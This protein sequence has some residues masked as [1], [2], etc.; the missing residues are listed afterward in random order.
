MNSERGNKGYTCGP[1]NKSVEKSSSFPEAVGM[2]EEFQAE[3]ESPMLKLHQ[4][5]RADDAG[6]LYQI[7]VATGSIMGCLY[8]GKTWEEGKDK[9]EELLSWFEP[10]KRTGF[11]RPKPDE[12]NDLT[13]LFNKCRVKVRSAERRLDAL[14]RDKTVESVVDENMIAYFNCLSSY[15]DYL[16][17]RELL[18]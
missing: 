14:M 17:S 8:T 18:K 7:V 6:K 4:I 1:K 16:R 11:L 13:I 2:I 10:I 9:V 3:L 15:F 12:L 5:G